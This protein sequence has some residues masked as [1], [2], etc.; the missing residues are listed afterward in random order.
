MYAEKYSKSPDVVAV[1]VKEK[2]YLQA[3]DKVK[4]LSNACSAEVAIITY[5]NST[6]V[7]SRYLSITLTRTLT[8]NLTTERLLP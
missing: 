3:N 1:L 2:W 7:H 6:N 4:N 5:N 8:I